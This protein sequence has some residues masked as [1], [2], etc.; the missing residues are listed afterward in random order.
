MNI[1]IFFLL[2]TP[3]SGFQS[4]CLQ[5]SFGHFVTCDASVPWYLWEYEVSQ[6]LGAHFHN[7]LVAPEMGQSSSLGSVFLVA[8][9][10]I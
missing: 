4:F 9:Q 5:Q 3:A 1:G 10:E 8:E 6:D 2:K 7:R